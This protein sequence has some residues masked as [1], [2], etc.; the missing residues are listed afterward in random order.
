MLVVTTF[1]CTRGNGTVLLKFAEQFV[2]GQYN[3]SPRF[4]SVF[5]FLREVSSVGTRSR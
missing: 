3:K 2:S 4:I 1:V 5:C